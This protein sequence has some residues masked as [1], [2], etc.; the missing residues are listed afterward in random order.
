MRKLLSIWVAGMLLALLAACGGGGGSAGTT[1]GSSGTSATAA[2]A[3][4]AAASATPKLTLELTDSAGTVLAINAVTSGGTFFVKASAVDAAGTAVS[5]VLVSFT[6]DNL[7]GTLSSSAAL[8]NAAG[9]ARVQITP[10]SL[11]AAN[12][13]QLTAQATVSTKSLTATLNYQTSAANVVIGAVTANPNSITAL[14]SSSVTASASV[15]GVAATAGQVSATFSASCGS[16]S[17]ATVATSSAGVATSTYQS[18]SSCSGAVSIT[19]SAAGATSSKGTITVAAAQAAN[20][21]YDSA[22]PTSMVVS[23]ATGI[24]QSTV[25][26]KVVD[27]GGAGMAGQSVT[28][29]LDAQSSAAGV[30]FNVGGA[31]TVANQTVSTD[32]SGFAS[33]I[34]QSGTLPTPVIVKATLSASMVAF[35]SGI[36]VTSG[37]ASQNNSSLSATKLS[38]EGLNTDGVQTT[39][40]MRASDRQGNPIPV[41]TAVSFVASHGTIQGSCLTDAN[42]SCSAIYTSSGQRPATGLVQILSYMDGEE[43]FLDGNGNNVWD[44]GETFYDMGVAFRDDN[45]NGISDVGE[46]TYPGGQTGSVSCASNSS[47]F[48]SV[49]DTCDGTWSSSIRVRRSAV[50]G[51]ASSFASITLSGV[52]TSNGFTVTIASAGNPGVGMPTGTTVAAAQGKGTGCTVKVSPSTVRNTAFAGDHFI[53]LDVAAAPAAGAPAGS[54]CSGSR[55]D[56]TVTAPSGVITIQGINIP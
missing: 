16:F 5:N 52:P 6:T 56:V 51:L 4:A 18:T 47:A 3:A 23:S 21:L 45:N 42:S 24:K 2:A 48:P 17:P 37:K 20:I 25:K 31:L 12:A 19:A 46:Q 39:L 34:I 14:Q 8:T 11:T 27:G 44:A 36:V 9:I 33:V 26:F 32:G 50:I 41:G 13:A 28:I 10:T 15:N 1:T 53:Q 29:S 7:I 22:T 43:S 54:G 38:I 35:S 55:I 30:S 40:T 49:T